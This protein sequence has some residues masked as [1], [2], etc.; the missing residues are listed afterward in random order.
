MLLSCWQ[1]YK[2]KNEKNIEG[3]DDKVDLSDDKEGPASDKA[4]ESRKW[5]EFY[6]KFEE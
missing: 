1:F 4:K 5:W 2:E 3:N 6:K